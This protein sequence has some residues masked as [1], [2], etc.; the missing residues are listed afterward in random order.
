[1]YFSRQQVYRCV[2]W[3]VL[4]MAYC[5]IAYKLVTYDGYAEWLQ[6]IRCAEKMHWLWLL[7]VLLF[8]PV[9]ILFESLKWQTLV[10]GIYPLSRRDALRCVCY[11]QLTAFVT[12]YRVGD[13]PGRIACM[14]SGT[15]SSGAL[16]TRLIGIGV[17]NSALITVVIMV[18]GLPAACFV[19]LRAD[20]YTTIGVLAI[21]L[22]A[23]GVLPF[24][25]KKVR[26]MQLLSALLYSVLRYGV[27]VMQ[28]ALVLY[29]CGIELSYWQ[30]LTLI[31]TY[32]L[33]VTITPSMPAADPAI[34]GSWLLV[35]LED[36]TDATASVALA[37]VMIWLFN[38]MLPM[39]A[40][41]CVRISKG[42]TE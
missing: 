6:Y 34:R 39:L 21:L 1:M 13:Y 40:G 38:T 8:V 35:V 32:Y 15:N 20:R 28:L 42:K 9:N 16:W 2:Q 5:F 11:G 3:V 31:P 36:Y 25:T 23:L 10:S 19:L 24:V 33:F 7:P 4:V 17:V 30:V 29:I 26:A 18:L 22:V 12:P 27:W 41:S 14:L 37:T